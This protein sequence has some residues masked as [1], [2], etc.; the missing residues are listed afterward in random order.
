MEISSKEGVKTNGGGIGVLPTELFQLIELYLKET[1]YRLLMNSNKAVF[2]LI[3]KETV[4][5]SLKLRK[6][7]NKTEALQLHQLIENVKDKSKQVSLEMLHRNQCLTVSYAH[8][9][10]GIGKLILKGTCHYKKEYFPF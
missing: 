6:E 7:L 3:K 5:Y 4:H 8:I 9:Y 2:G 1:D 10:G